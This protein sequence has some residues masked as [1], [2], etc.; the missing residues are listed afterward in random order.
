MSEPTSPMVENIR[1]EAA[2]AL[3]DV[4]M[5]DLRDMF[6]AQMGTEQNAAFQD[7]SQG[8]EWILEKAAARLASA[9]VDSPEFLCAFRQASRDSIL[10]ERA[11]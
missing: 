7:S 6:C 5:S 1:R 3:K 4:V 2:E 11:G 9:F 8:W 10:D